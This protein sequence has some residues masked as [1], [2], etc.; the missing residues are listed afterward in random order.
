MS[1]PLQRRPWLGRG[2]ATAGAAAA[3]AVHGVALWLLLLQPPVVR[4]TEPE[5]MSISLLAT[6][7]PADPTP[8]T[9]S[10]QA[11]PIAAPQP[12][13]APTPPRSVKPHK[14]AAV[15]RPTQPRLAAAK[16]TPTTTAAAEP[17]SAPPTAATPPA[18]TP[19]EP[20][21]AEPI[22]VAPRF[23]AAYLNNPAPPY[24]PLSRRLGEQGRV[25]VRVFVEPGGAPAQVELRASSGHRRLD[26]AAVEAVR[27]WRFVPARRGAEPVGAWVLVPI[28][29][30]LRS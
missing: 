6:P 28:S 12:L 2:E 5:I 10:P 18:T 7:A 14:P 21:I 26:A 3:L 27:R 22:L 15:R 16:P 9:P 1:S 19:A 20:A 23:N 11:A 30:N 17:G 13:A 8:S 25:V 4:Q 29:F 24:P